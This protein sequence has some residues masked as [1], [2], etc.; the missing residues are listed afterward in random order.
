MLHDFLSR[1]RLAMSSLGLAAFEMR[2]TNAL[3]GTVSPQN[4]A[5]GSSVDVKLFGAKGDGVT[6]DTNAINAAIEE[7]RHRREKG[8]RFPMIPRLV[9]SP[10]VYRL[11]GTVNLTML[12]DFNTIIDGGGAVLLGCCA[13]KPV[14]DALG[15]RWL[16]IRDLVVFGDPDA[17][18]SVGLQI[19]RVAR[20]NADDHLFEN[21][22]I[23]GSF[24][25]ACLYN[26][27]AETSC[28]LHLILSNAH[29]QAYCLIQD[30]VDHFGVS[31][32]FVGDI[33]SPNHDISFNENLFLNCDF[34]C[35]SDGIPVWLGDTSRHSFIRCYAATGG[36]V[37]FR[38]FSGWRGNVMMHID[39]HC[40][41]ATLSSVIMFDGVKKHL[42]VFGFEFSDH[43]C[44]AKRSLLSLSSNVTSIQMTGV[45]IVVAK[46]NYTDCRLVDDPRNWRLTGS[47]ASDSVTS[48]NC[49]SR[50]SG[51]VTL[52]EKMRLVN[53]GN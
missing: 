2:P 24:S 52:G 18:P 34:R 23:F 16:T 43:Y 28:F 22:K 48:W 9:F 26:H 49:E 13:G 37:A 39:C 7:L 15:A 6:D 40:E 29:E 32:Q 50:F 5:D 33:V 53:V 46:Y 19:G 30:G 45:N 4:V 25:L 35:S 44:F 38:V 31:S 47:Y 27:A 8:L 42:R 20:E 10:G 1:R 12:R 11:E 41:I 51:M 21:V 17:M 3:S 36:P 14:I